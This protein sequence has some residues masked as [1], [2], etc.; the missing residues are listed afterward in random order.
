MQNLMKDY[1]GK[2]FHINP[3]RPTVFGLP[4][5]KTPERGFFNGGQMTS[6]EPGGGMGENRYHLGKGQILGVPAST[7]SYAPHIFG[8]PSADSRVSPQFG[9]D[10]DT[11]FCT[12]K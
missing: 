8:P 10:G 6:S 1:T 3:G 4:V 9:A 7:N 5:Y 11:E 12:T 2:N